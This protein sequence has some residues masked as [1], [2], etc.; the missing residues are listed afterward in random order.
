M[1]NKAEIRRLFS[2]N[3]L[4]EALEAMVSDYPDAT[5]LLQKYSAAEREKNLGTI[6]FDEWMRAQSQVSAA[7]LQL[8]LHEPGTQ[9]TSV[10]TS[11]GPVVD[12]SRQPAVSQ[13]IPWIIGLLL[14][15]GSAIAL[16]GFRPCP[17]LNEE[18][19]FNLL[20]ALGAAGIATILPGLFHFEI[21]GIKAGSAIGIFVLV[22]LVKPA[23]AVKDDSRC[24][25]PFEFTIALQ[26]DKK[27]NLSPQYPE[28]ESNATLMIRLDN[29]WRPAQV[30]SYGDAN[31]RSIPHN[32]KDSMVAAKFSEGTKYWTLA[33][34]SVLL[35]GKSA[36]LFIIPDGSLGKVEGRVMSFHNN[37][38]PLVGATVNVLGLTTQSN[39]NGDFSLE[40]PLSKQ[41][42][43]YKVDITLAGYLPYSGN[44]S[45][46]GDRM[47]VLLEKQKTSRK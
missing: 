20:M 21:K 17:S 24:N 10:P 23:G 22:Y 35:S 43:N 13:H 29:D 2:Q 15:V 47:R 5:V 26:K 45:P 18:R 9:S 6:S 32:F 39:E 30:D 16:V 11:S 1:L 44:A 42:T 28:L 37:G 36:R 8:L 46:A 41:A 31:Y 25:L 33:K 38:Q 34:D 40:I 12:Q 19:V 14:L 3:L 7:G 4:K 27:L